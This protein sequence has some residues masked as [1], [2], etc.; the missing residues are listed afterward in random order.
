[1]KLKNKKTIGII[2]LAIAVIGAIAGA[3]SLFKF[4]EYK[5]IISEIQ[6]ENIVLD[7]VADGI[8]TGAFDAELVA[9]SVEVKVENHQ[10]K[11]VNLLEHYNG[12]GEPAEV[13]IDAIIEQQ[14]IKVDTI[15]GATNSSLVIM[16]AI[17]NA[18][19][20]SPMQ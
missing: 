11:A 9:V 15:S 10:I 5:K 4:S 2:L 18:L 19:K 14:S 17:E 6:I 13:I 8:Y 16:K 20:N 1:M 12:K 3:Q 7:E